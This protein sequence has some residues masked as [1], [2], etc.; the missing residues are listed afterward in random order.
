MVRLYDPIKHWSDNDVMEYML[1]LVK[2]VEPED[3]PLHERLLALSTSIKLSAEQ[4]RLLRHKV[5]DL[6]EKYLGEE[7]E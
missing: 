6:E 4:I 1:Q 2:K 3:I 5:C 7:N